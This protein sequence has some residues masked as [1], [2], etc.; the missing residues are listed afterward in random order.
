M[1]T[2][3][4]LEFSMDAKLDLLAPLAIHRLAIR[5]T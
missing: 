5:L 3:D 4:V 1:T 2:Y